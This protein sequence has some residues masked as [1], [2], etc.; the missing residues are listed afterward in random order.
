MGRLPLPLVAVLAGVL[1]CAAQDPLEEQL[2]AA[3]TNRDRD[4][5]VSVQQRSDDPAADDLGDPADDFENDLLA[6]DADAPS[7]DGGVGVPK[8]KPVRQTASIDAGPPAA[9]PLCGSA[10]NET[11]QVIPDMLIVLDRSG[12]MKTPGRPGSPGVDRWTPSV[13]GVKT[14]TTTFDKSVAFGLMVF[15]NETSLCAPGDVRVPVGKSTAAKIGMALDAIQPAGGTPTGETLQRALTSFQQSQSKSPRYVL[16]VTDG[17]P[18]CPNAQGITIVPET[19]AADK[20]HTIA[21]IDALTKA[22]IKTF[23]VGYD[24]QLDPALATALGEFAQHGGTNKYYP[25]QNEKSLVDAF[26]AITKTIRS[27]D[28]KFKEWVDD[29]RYLTVT[30]DNKKLGLNDPNGWSFKDQTITLVGEACA[31]Y[32]ENAVHK[33][34]IKLE[35]IPQ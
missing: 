25:V 19:L 10:D 26:T 15:P 8:P 22:G 5:Q 23:V 3:G 6:D 12:S 9:A 31:V 18:T 16:L 28:F 35:C 1:G 2:Q 21:A 20:A 32:Q 30:L 4:P 29:P 34:S 7:I 14:L 24:A 13:S 11:Q 33:V 27:C 17:Q